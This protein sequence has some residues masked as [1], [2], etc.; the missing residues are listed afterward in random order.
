MFCVDF[1]KHLLYNYYKLQNMFCMVLLFMETRLLSIRVS[2]DL[3]VRKVV[4]D[5]GFSKSLY[6]RWENGTSDIPLSAAV[7][8]AEYF[9][10]SLDYLTYLS[11]ECDYSADKN[12]IA[13]FVS[14]IVDFTL[15]SDSPYIRWVD[16]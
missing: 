5:L 7:K 12:R 11:N 1:T 8:L 15:S 3:T 4:D 2:R 6:R 16:D 9:N 13:S 10:V 14:M